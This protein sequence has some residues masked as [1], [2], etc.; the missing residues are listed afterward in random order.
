M[1]QDVVRRFGTGGRC[2]CNDGV[3]GTGGTDAMKVRGTGGR[4]KM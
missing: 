2:R 4:R 3:L 1:E